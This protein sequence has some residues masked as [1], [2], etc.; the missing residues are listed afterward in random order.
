MCIQETLKMCKICEKF[1][2]KLCNLLAFVI[3]F[4]KSYKM[5]KSNVVG[6]NMAGIGKIRHL[7]FGDGDGPNLCMQSKKK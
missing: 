6:L 3:S 2:S 5:L 7:K 4:P 1:Q